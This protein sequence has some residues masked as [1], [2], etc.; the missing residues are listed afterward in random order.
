MESLSEGS[1]KPL[2]PHLGTFM[3]FPFEQHSR[4]MGP[5]SSPRLI[6][7]EANQERW[8]NDEGPVMLKRTP[9]PKNPKT[10]NG[11][12]PFSQPGQSEGRA[13]LDASG[14]ALQGSLLCFL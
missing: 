13:D 2:E 11:I 12:E 4:H 14:E 9:K 3:A 7:T 1:T 10:R 5:E 8:S 6:F